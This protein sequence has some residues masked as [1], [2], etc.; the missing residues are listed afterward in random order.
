M[1]IQTIDMSD[2]GDTLITLG[3][4]ASLISSNIW[5][6]FKIVST[7]LALRYFW[8]LPFGK[9][10]IP[11]ILR[12]DFDWGRRGSSTCSLLMSF[13]FFMY[14]LMIWRSDMLA[15]LLVTITMLMGLDLMKS[16]TMSN[17]AFLRS[18]LILATWNA[19]FLMN[20]L[21]LSLLMEMIICFLDGPFVVIWICGLG[22]GLPLMML[23][24]CSIWLAFKAGK[25]S[26][27]LSTSEVLTVCLE[28]WAYDL[29]SFIE[30]DVVLLLLK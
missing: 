30:F 14:W 24:T 17:L 16:T 6:Y 5:F 8:V 2:L 18:L 1:S 15:T 23:L 29:V 10:G 13:D 19:E 20:E 12:Y 28:A 11:M 3:L 27:I 9:K 22:F 7:S 26:L 21:L 4:E 25:D